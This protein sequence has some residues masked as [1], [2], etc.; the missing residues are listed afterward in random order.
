MVQAHE[1]VPMKAHDETFLREVPASLRRHHCDE[2]PPRPARRPG[3]FYGEHNRVR[4]GIS[5]W[6][7]PISKALSSTAF[8]G[9]L[10][11]II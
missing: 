2:R 6:E 11:E 1:N 7:S 9:F 5:A 8:R 3:P 10:G 4:E